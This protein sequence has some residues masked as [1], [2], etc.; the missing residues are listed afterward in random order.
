MWSWNESKNVCNF[1]EAYLKEVD[2][3]FSLPLHTA[4]WNIDVKS[5]AAMSNRNIMQA[6]DAS[7]KS[8]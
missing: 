2:V 5:R 3:T 6:T 7:Y 8:N 4:V 1:W